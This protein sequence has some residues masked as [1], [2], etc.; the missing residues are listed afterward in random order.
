MLI[1]WHVISHGNVAHASVATNKENI[2]SVLKDATNQ[3]RNWIF[4]M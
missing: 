3:K 1:N 2:K 4:S